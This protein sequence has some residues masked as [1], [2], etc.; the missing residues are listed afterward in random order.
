T[1]DATFTDPNN[2]FASAD[3][4]QFVQ[5]VNQGKTKLTIASSSPVPVFGEPVTIT[6]TISPLLPPATVGS[7]N[8]S[9]QVTFTLDG[10]P[11][12]SGPVNLDAAGRA[13]I[14]LTNLSV[15]LHRIRVSYTGDTNFLSVQSTSDFNLTVIKDNTTV[16]VASSPA[17]I[18]VGQSVIFSATVSANAPG[19][20]SPSGTVN[21][22]DGAAVSANFLGTAP[23]VGGVATISTSSL[24]VGSNHTIRAVYSGDTN[25]NGGSGVL[26]NFAVNKGDTTVAVTGSTSATIFGQPVTFTA[27]VTNISAL[28][29]GTPTGT[30][31]F[32]VDGVPQPTNAPL[33]TLGKATFVTSTLP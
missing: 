5:T 4:P 19:S 14:T 15:N 17:S 12:S 28:F 23:I 30:V 13:A 7:V 31:T 8:P 16:D 1:I 22:F 25:F 21:F 18:L 9:G 20:G 3:A 33:N 10:V 32:F 27:T 24:K 26:T 6:A 2:N 29:L 11:L